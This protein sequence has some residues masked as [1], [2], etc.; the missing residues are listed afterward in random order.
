[1][2]IYNE[3]TCKCLIIRYF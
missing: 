2:V 1:M 3:R